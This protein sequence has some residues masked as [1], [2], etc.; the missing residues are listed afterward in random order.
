M[1]T[2]TKPKSTPPA[3]KKQAAK[4]PKAVMGRKPLPPEK[5][6]LL[7]GIY[8]SPETFSLA[9][10]T[11]EALGLPVGT[12]LSRAADLGMKIISTKGF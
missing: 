4:K 10:A 12:V 7:K 3:S 8:I 1:T 2:Q 5:R 9:T 11:A 6:K